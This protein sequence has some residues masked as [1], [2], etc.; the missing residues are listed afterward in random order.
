MF[1]QDAYKYAKERARDVKVLSFKECVEIGVRPKMNR[2]TVQATLF[3]YNV[4]LYIPGYPSRSC[5]P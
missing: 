3:Y 1:E 4:F 2:K 5:V